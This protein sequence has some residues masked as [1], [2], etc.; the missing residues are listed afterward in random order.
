MVAH[1]TFSLQLVIIGPEIKDVHLVVSDFDGTLLGSRREISSRTR[2]VLRQLHELGIEFVVATGRPP[3]YC[4]S[5][6]EQTG[7]PTT[8]LCANGAVEYDPA[9]GTINQLATLDLD[10]AR[11]LLVEIRQ[12]FPEAGFCAEM[13]SDFVAERRWLELASRPADSNIAD[14]VPL[15]NERVHKLLI[16]LPDISADE[17]LSLIDPLLRGRA[18]AMHAGLPFVELMPPGVDKA[19]GLK[20]LCDERR[21]SAMEVVAFGDMPND[22]AMLQFAGWGVAVRNA[23]NST[24][25]AA[26]EITDSNVNDGVAKVLERMM[27]L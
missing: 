5:I 18:N 4:D 24:Q 3:R 11:D 2:E 26:N 22:D 12:A 6:A 16:N 14:V 25:N 8:L 10:N 20:R 13:G 9:S 7:I 17:T 1:R 23:H 21:I 19:F 15:L 27:G